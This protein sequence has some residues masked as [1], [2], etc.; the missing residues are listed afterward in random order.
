MA[1]IGVGVGMNWK[2]YAEALR[3]AEEA[4]EDADNPD[5]ESGGEGGDEGESDVDKL[6]SSYDTKIAELSKKLKDMEDKASEADFSTQSA[7]AYQTAVNEVNGLISRAKTETDKAKA[8]D[9]VLNA[10][11]TLATAYGNSRHGFVQTQSLLK[12][13]KAERLASQLQFAHG[14]D[15]ASYKARLMEAKTQD[16]MQVKYMQIDLEV[17]KGGK[18]KKADNNRGGPRIDGGG[19]GGPARTNVLKE[20]QDIDVSTPE[21]QEEWRKKSSGFRRKLSGTGA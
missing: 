9:L 11:P 18:G 16:E 7:Q 5:D 6:K 15:V 3:F 8:L 21:G 10:L 19:R 12:A 20:M 2:L 4:D 14:G 1:G 13:E 17:A